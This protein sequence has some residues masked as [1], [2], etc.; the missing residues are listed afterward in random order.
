MRQRDVQQLYR[1]SRGMTLIAR[2]KSEHD[3]GRRRSAHDMPSVLA[4]LKV[5]TRYITPFLVFS[6]RHKIPSLVTPSYV[7]L[8]SYSNST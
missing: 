4:S 5:A 3:V 1:A 7:T 6:L 2:Q 8:F